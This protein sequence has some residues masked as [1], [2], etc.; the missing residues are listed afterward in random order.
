LRFAADNADFVTRDQVD[1]GAFA[2]IGLSNNCD[3]SELVGHGL[4][5]PPEEDV[6]F[7]AVPFFLELL[8]ASWIEVDLF[9]EGELSFTS[10]S[11]LASSTC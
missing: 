7:D 5:S 8:F 6:E 11:S 4:V 1:Q 9:G 2:N 10:V 3:L